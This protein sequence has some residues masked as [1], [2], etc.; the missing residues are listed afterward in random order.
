MLQQE[1]CNIPA[2][3]YFLVLAGS[4]KILKRGYLYNIMSQVNEEAPEPPQE[5]TFVSLAVHA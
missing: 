3:L 4:V 1:K 5:L 2:L